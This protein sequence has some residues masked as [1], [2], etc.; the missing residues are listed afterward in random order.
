[1]IYYIILYWDGRA[2][3]RARKWRVA[4]RAPNRAASGGLRCPSVSMRSEQQGGSQQSG[5]FQPSES[6]Y[7]IKPTVCMSAEGIT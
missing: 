2:A 3:R 1:M 7:Y 4:A 5:S 6:V